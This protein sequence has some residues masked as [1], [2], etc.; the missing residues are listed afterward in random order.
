MPLPRRPHSSLH[1]PAV[2]QRLRKTRRPRHSI[3][4]ILPTSSSSITSRWEDVEVLF[5][6]DALHTRTGSQVYCRDTPYVQRKEPDCLDSSAPCSDVLGNTKTTLGH[7]MRAGFLSTQYEFSTTY[8]YPR[9]HPRHA[10]SSPSSLIHLLLRSHPRPSSTTPSAVVSLK[11]AY[12]LGVSSLLVCP[13]SSSLF[14]RRRHR[15][16][17]PLGL[18]RRD[19]CR[20]PTPPPTRITGRHPLLHCTKL[21]LS[22]PCA[23]PLAASPIH[24]V[25]ES[26]A[27]TYLSLGRGPSSGNSASMRASFSRISVAH[28]GYLEMYSKGEAQSSDENSAS[29]SA[30][31]L[32]ARARHASL[33]RV[34]MWTTF[35]QHVSCCGRV[36]YIPSRRFGRH[37]SSWA[38]A[39]PGRFPADF[40]L[41]ALAVDSRLLSLLLVSHS[42][43]PA[44]VPPASFSTVRARSPLAG[45]V[46]APPS[47]SELWLLSYSSPTSAGQHAGPPSNLLITLSSMS[48]WVGGACVRTPHAAH[49]RTSTPWMRSYSLWRCRRWRLGCPNGDI[50][51]SAVCETK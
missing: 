50:S 28:P 1:P 46:D 7:G 16:R 48:P 34:L 27:Q 11:R 29:T 45:G 33:L 4:A 31:S 23:R 21:E 42:R 13:S 41:L 49:T 35:P 43:R 5:A 9:P 10:C 26:R 24:L 18:F 30:F 36:G 44:A 14:V 12:D 19:L 20:S 6:L 3:N 37:W 8:R 17:T 39:H 2:A 15:R 51:Q 22:H 38:Y 40:P 47:T 32:C 25:L